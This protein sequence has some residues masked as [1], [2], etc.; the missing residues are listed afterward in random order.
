[1]SDLGPLSFYLGIEVHQ[2]DSG[3]T[4]RQT[5]YDK[6]VIELGGLTDCNPTLTPMEER[7]KLSH[8]SMAEEVD[9]TQYRRLVGSLRYLA[10]MRLDLAFFVSNVSRFMQRPMTEHK[11][12]IKRI[13][14]YIEGTLD[15]GLH[16]SRCPGV[17]H[18]IGYSDSNHAG[19]IDTSKSTRGMLFFLGNC[20]VSW[21]SVK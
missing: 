10:H 13:V 15:Y 19:D 5:T 11:Q 17:A 4:L 9:A 12:A 2:D 8:D 14:H 7:L 6:R 3:I 21:Q 1:M 18:F 20:L 16:Y